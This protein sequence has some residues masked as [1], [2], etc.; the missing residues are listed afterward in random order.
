MISLN[1]FSEHIPTYGIILYVLDTDNE[2]NGQRLENQY[3][4]SL[5]HNVPNVPFGTLIPFSGHM[6]VFQ[7][8]NPV[9]RRENPLNCDEI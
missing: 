6:P 1:S 8:N 7:I 2:G 4:N 5:L 3:N 9:N